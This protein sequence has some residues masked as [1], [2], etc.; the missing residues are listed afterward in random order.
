M[1]LSL[2]LAAALCFPSAPDLWKGGPL[3]DE[4]MKLPS[5]PVFAPDQQLQAQVRLYRQLRSPFQRSRMAIEFSETNNPAAFRLLLNLLGSEKDSFVQDNIL[6]SLLR[7][8]RK[9]YGGVF[10]L[11]II[12]VLRLY[13]SKCCRLW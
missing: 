8:Q 13:R 5:A 9:G 11:R 3:T 10:F 2:F 7:L 4:V 6:E 12:E 1:N